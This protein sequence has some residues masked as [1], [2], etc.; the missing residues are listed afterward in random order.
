MLK[1]DLHGKTKLQLT[2]KE[3][4]LLLVLTAGLVIVVCLALYLASHTSNGDSRSS[5]RHT[6]EQPVRGD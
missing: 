6:A 5:P 1:K 2:R 4:A 3:R